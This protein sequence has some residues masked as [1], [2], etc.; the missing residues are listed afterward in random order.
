MCVV[1]ECTVY[2][3][4]YLNPAKMGHRRVYSYSITSLLYYLKLYLVHLCF[5]AVDISLL[6]GTEIPEKLDSL[7]GFPEDRIIISGQ[8]EE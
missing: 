3:S 8:N 7:C 4:G 6:S 5:S 1:I 2:T